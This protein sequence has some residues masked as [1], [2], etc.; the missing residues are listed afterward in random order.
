MIVYDDVP[1]DKIL[2]LSALKEETNNNIFL[3]KHNSKIKVIYTGV[4]KINATIATLKACQLYPNLKTII[5]FGTAG[6]N[7]ISKG[8]LVECTKF[9]QRDMDARALGFSLGET[10]YEEIPKLLEFK[11][12]SL[13]HKKNIICG[14][15]DSFCTKIDYDLVDMEAYAI[16]KICWI[17]KINFISYKYIS[18]GGDAEEWKNNTSKGISKFKK[19]IKTL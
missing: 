12:K 9:V 3:N 19:I 7:T 10:P 18:D 5:N 14:T 8:E 16:A 4:G 17:S 15:G 6:S 2:I 13:K 1:L 11:N